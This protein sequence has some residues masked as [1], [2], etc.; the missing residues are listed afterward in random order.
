MDDLLK[1]YE[2]APYPSAAFPGMHPDTLATTAQLWGM[3]P[4]PIEKCRFLE[5]GSGTGENLLAMAAALP[6]SHF[7]G[8]DLSPGQTAFARELASQLGLANVTLHAGDIRE[9]GG[10][11]G[12]FDYIGAHGVYSWCP[13]E[14]QNA[15]LA[16]CAR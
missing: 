2:E 11:L 13:P 12:E 5:I 8:V 9:I 7:V 15:I 3:R 6:Q 4:A 14:V 16:L 1:S 10:E